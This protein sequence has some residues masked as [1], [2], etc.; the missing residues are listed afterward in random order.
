MDDLRRA[1]ALVRKDLLT[2]RRSKAAFNAMAFFAALVAP[3]IFSR[4]SE[5]TLP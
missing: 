5:G 3:L 1:V 2:E 4:L